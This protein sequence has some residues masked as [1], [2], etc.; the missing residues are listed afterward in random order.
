MYSW[1]LAGVFIFAWIKEIPRVFLRRTE[2]LQLSLFQQ[3][4]GAMLKWEIISVA[5]LFFSVHDDIYVLLFDIRGSLQ[6]IFTGYSTTF[7]VESSIAPRVVYMK[8]R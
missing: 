3:M 4:N 5:N 2:V 8:H 6:V 1:G 7:G